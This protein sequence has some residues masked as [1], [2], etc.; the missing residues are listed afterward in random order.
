L[1]ECLLGLV[2]SFELSVLDGNNTLRFEPEIFVTIIAECSN[3]ASNANMVPLLKNFPLMKV[4]LQGVLMD[5][6]N[7]CDIMSNIELEVKN[8]LQ[9]VTKFRQQLRK[10]YSPEYVMD[11]GTKT[12]DDSEST[13]KFDEKNMWKLGLSGANVAFSLNVGLFAER[14]FSNNGLSSNDGFPS[15][16]VITDGVVKSNLAHMLA[17]D[18]IIQKLCKEGIRCNIIQVG[19]RRGLFDPGVDFGLL[20]DNEILQ[21]VAT[22]TSGVFILSE[23]RSDLSSANT[24]NESRQINFFKKILFIETTFSKKNR[25]RDRNNPVHNVNTFNFPWDPR[26]QPPSFKPMTTHYKDYSLNLV[27]V[28]QLIFSRIRHGFSIDSISFLSG[29]GNNNNKVDK[30]SITMSRLWSPNVSIQYKIKANWQGERNGILKLKSNRIEINLLAEALSAAYL[31]NF[32]TGRPNDQSHPLYW[33]FVSLYNFLKTICISD[34]YLK[35]HVYHRI[36]KENH[37]LHYRHV[38]GNVVPM[39]LN[40]FE[41]LKQLW[42]VKEEHSISFWCD[43]IR[44]N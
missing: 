18:D 24:P 27:D 20:P 2:Q 39:S 42:K 31:L 40:R 36:L 3:F 15:L 6:Q 44:F 26:S 17:G 5:N 43:D 4:L 32:Q 38:T 21:F 7:V 25:S 28:P 35:Q 10:E 1:R 34:E 19:S 13:P 11:M 22:A 37:R 29:N 14:L 30:I 41:M 12:D 8:F 33:R 16:I 23:D 9:E